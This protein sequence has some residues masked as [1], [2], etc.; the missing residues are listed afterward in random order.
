MELSH[1]TTILFSEDQFSS[2]KRISK[3]KGKSIG[4]LIRKACIQIYS[5]D[6]REG[7]VDAVLELGKLKLP[8][9]SVQEMKKEQ[10]PYKEI[11]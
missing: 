10:I 8:V 1:K 4:E 2:L 6:D 3:E 7:A 11:H 9:A 5:I